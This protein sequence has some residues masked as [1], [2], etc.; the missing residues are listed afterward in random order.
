MIKI[1]I[2]RDYFTVIDNPCALCKKRVIFILYVFEKI[3]LRLYFKE[4]KIFASAPG[5]IFVYD[6]F[7]CFEIIGRELD[8]L[9][10][11]VYKYFEMQMYFFLYFVEESGI[12]FTTALFFLSFIEKKINKHPTKLYPAEKLSSYLVCKGHYL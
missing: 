10:Y 3:F 12:T 1:Y 11:N 2:F 4:N 6:M 8:T 7:T 9:G 5:L